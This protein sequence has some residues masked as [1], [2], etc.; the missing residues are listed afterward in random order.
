MALIVLLASLVALPQLGTGGPTDAPPALWERIASEDSVTAKEA[1][2]EYSQL[3]EKIIAAEAGVLRDY[4]TEGTR[5]VDEQEHGRIDRA[6][7]AIRML[8]ELRAESE[9]PL[10]TEFLMFST[11][12]GNNFTIR[13]PPTGR[14]EEVYGLYPA[15]NALAKMGKQSIAACVIA[16]R[17]LPKVSM[18]TGDY[19]QYLA[20]AR[21]VAFRRHAA[22]AIVGI[23]GRPAAEAALNEFAKNAGDEKDRNAASNLLLGIHL[24]FSPEP[25]S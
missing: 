6:A 11:R 20:G 7:R 5:S 14:I 3:R 1:E 13:I 12:D 23:A 15:I 19:E 4:L 10:L 22:L 2:Q 21:I 9:I 17:D 24:I 18:M 8:G 25:E 16:V